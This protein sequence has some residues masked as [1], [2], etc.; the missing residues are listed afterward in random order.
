MLAGGE[1]RHRLDQLGRRG[2]DAAG[3]ARRQLQVHD[4]VARAVRQVDRLGMVDVA[5]HV[6]RRAVR[7]D[8]GGRAHGELA[9]RQHVGVEVELRQ[10]PA[11]RAHGPGAGAH[12]AVEVAVL[13]LEVLRLE[14]QAF[15]PDNLVLPVHRGRVAG[16]ATREGATRDETTWKGAAWKRAVRTG[17]FTVRAITVWEAAGE[18]GFRLLPSRR[19]V[20][21]SRLCWW[22]G[23]PGCRPRR[24]SWPGEN[25]E[26]RQTRRSPSPGRSA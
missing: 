14:E 17:D 13:L 1:A 11:E 23:A 5:G 3:L 4:G 16:W 9:E 26:G 19:R 15:R 6:E 12:Q 2:F 8:P 7:H 18:A 20:R 25:R 10:P 22:C 24:A 21:H